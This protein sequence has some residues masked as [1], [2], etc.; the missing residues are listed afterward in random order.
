MW[1]NPEDII[2]SEACQSRKGKC[3]SSLLVCGP[4]ADAVTEIQGGLGGRGRGKGTYSLRGQSARL[5]D[6]PALEVDGGNSYTTM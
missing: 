6:E 2:L 4:G 5:E 3:C 1:L